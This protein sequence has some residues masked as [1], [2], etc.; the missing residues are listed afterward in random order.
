MVQGFYI[1]LARPLA[2]S[3]YSISN[4]NNGENV[5]VQHFSLLCHTLFLEM[6]LFLLNF[7]IAVLNYSQHTHL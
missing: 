4:T 1:W 3:N 2:P 7:P 5:T 6:Q